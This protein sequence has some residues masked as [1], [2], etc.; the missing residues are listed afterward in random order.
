KLKGTTKDRKFI[1]VPEGDLGVSKTDLACP[2]G[3]GRQDI[4]L[5]KD[6]SA[7]RKIFATKTLNTQHI[8]IQHSSELC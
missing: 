6:S 5:P 1:K 7:S 4:L 8:N 3:M 2:V